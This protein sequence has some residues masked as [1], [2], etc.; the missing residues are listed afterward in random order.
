MLGSEGTFQKMPEELY[1][2]P[3][4]NAQYWETSEDEENEKKGQKGGRGKRE[5]R[6]KSSICWTSSSSSSNY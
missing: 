6:R 1:N 2:N 3:D 5:G 4:M